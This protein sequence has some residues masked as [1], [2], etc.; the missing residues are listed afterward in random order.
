MHYKVESERPESG[1][2][3]LERTESGMRDISVI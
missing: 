2:R 1:L 3:P